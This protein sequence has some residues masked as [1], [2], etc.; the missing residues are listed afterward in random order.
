MV[1]IKRK[2]TLNIFNDSAKVKWIVYPI[3]YKNQKYYI[4]F[5]C[6][7]R[8]GLKDKICIEEKIIGYQYNEK[9]KF[10]V[11]CKREKIFTLKSLVVPGY[12]VI[13]DMKITSFDDFKMNLP[14]IMSGVFKLYEETL[15]IKKFKE[16]KMRKTEE[17][18]GRI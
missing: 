18:N 3:T 10:F 17:W 2:I 7:V 4:E 14:E 5:I 15:N 9:C 6:S 13:Y 1:N 16:E 12:D 11:G 8:I